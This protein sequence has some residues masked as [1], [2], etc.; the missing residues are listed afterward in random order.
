MDVSSAGCCVVVEFC[1]CLRILTL[2]AGGQSAA[3]QRSPLPAGPFPSFRE[4]ATVHLVRPAM[5]TTTPWAGWCRSL[6]MCLHIFFD[7]LPL[8]SRRAQF[9]QRLS[10]DAPRQNPVFVGL[11]HRRSTS[12]SPADILFIEPAA[13]N[14]LLEHHESLRPV[15]AW[16]RP[17]ANTLRKCRSSTQQFPRSAMPGA[18]LSSSSVYRFHA[19]P[20]LARLISP[21]ICSRR[22]LPPTSWFPRWCL[23]KRGSIEP[24]ARLG[25][26]RA[27]CVCSQPSILFAVST[28]PNFCPTFHFLHSRGFKAVFVSLLHLSP[29]TPSCFISCAPRTRF[30]HQHGRDQEPRPISSP[31][32]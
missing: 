24:P 7:C 23:R 22:T 14:P 2:A 25:R 26:F 10:L 11:L 17:E 15:H 19:P 21:Y 8:F 29:S 13:T 5:L 32:T 20:H 27:P 4:G 31:C 6:D 3:A 9:L 28:R 16:D 30:F 1:Y 12:L 18:Q